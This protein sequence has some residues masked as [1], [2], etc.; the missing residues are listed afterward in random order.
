MVVAYLRERFPLTLYVP[1]GVVIA[2]PDLRASLFAVL[3]LLQ[4][5]VWDDLA[6]RHR[7]ALSHPERVVVRAVT[8]TPLIALCGALAVLN[9]CI[10]VWRDGSGIAVAALAALNGL[11][12]AWYLARSGRTALGDHL[13]L[14]K[15]PAM[16]VIVAGPRAA[17]S[18]YLVVAI[19]ALTYLVACGYEAWHDRSGPIARYLSI[20]GQ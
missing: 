20:G 19:A 11:F 13:L 3:L 16:V 8:V 9:I 2:S 14:A 10:A 15:Y 1:L 12:G 17:S 5:R 4:F 18:P 6:D 7:D